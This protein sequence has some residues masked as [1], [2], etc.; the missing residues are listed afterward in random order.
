M[1]RTSRARARASK[2]GQGPA[3]TDPWTVYLEEAILLHRESLSFRPTPHP[4]RFDSLRCLAC[5]LWDRF[6]TTGS[7]TDLE[8]AI[9]MLREGLSLSYAS[10]HPRRLWA[11]EN[12]ADI[13]ETRFKK[14]GNQSD[15]EQ[16][17]ALR[18]E[19]LAM[20]K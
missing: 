8:E 12:L 14:N 17:A 10:T 20:S 2:I 13:L 9:S 3:R 1:A 15:F 16:A 5:A 4:D 19:I 11:L 7:M 6:R 18:Q